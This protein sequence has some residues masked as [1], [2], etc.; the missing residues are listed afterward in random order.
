MRIIALPL[1]RPGTNPTS[2]LPIFYRY[3]IIAPP[4]IK[5]P[6]RP[7][8][9]FTRWMPEEG[10]GKWA[11]H[12][13]NA[14]WTGFGMAPEG[15]IKKRAFTLGERLMDQLDFEES[16]LKTIDLSIAPPL[17]GDAEVSNS[18]GTI[19]V[20]LLYP[21]T[22]LS[23]PQALDHL[24][25]LVDERIPI[26][27]RGLMLYIFFAVLSAPLKLIP[28]IPNFPFYFCAWRSWS[29]WKAKRAAQYIQGLIHNNRIVPVPLPS[30][31][32]VYSNLAP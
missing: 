16:N 15:T 6:L 1:V 7:T 21:P 20:P 10:L 13:A 14:T 4:P 9:F 22:V 11:S 28:I 27:N 29:H 19:Q 3:K 8:G 26:H 2:K 12:K 31:N 23:S 5:K 17:K 25:A 30:L 24:K 32:S 18:K